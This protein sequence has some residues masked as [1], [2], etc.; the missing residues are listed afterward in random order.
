M[1]SHAW[2]ALLVALLV[3][4]VA[5]P[6]PD[7]P[8]SYPATK[9]VD[10]TDNYHGTAVADPYRWLEDDVRT[11]SDVAAWVA[12]QNKVTEAFLKAIPERAA[13]QRRLTE[14]WN[15]ERYT[16]PYKEGGRYFYSKNDG[17]QNQ[18]VLY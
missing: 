2:P 3:L 9:R 11:D 13:I 12:E 14:L 5:A 6:A 16:V 8:P 1:S 17:L 18:N 4:A 10:H 7:G 15:Y